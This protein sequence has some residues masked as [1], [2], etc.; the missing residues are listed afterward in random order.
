MKG[1]LLDTNVISHLAPRKDGTGRVPEQFAAWLR[2]NAASIFV[3]TISIMEIRTGINSLRR[4]GAS[5][6]AERLSAWLNA[7]LDQFE[8]RVLPV[9]LSVAERAGD[10]IDQA[11]GIGRDLGVPDVLIAATAEFNDLC[12]LTANVRHFESLGLSVAIVDPFQDLPKPLS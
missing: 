4:Q 7:I 12:L 2:E 11:R 1:W 6:R 5:E 8:D 10:L 9:S 3:S